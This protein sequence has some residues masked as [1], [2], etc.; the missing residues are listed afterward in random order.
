MYWPYL[1]GENH[2]KWRMERPQFHQHNYK[3]SN[4]P[5]EAILCHPDTWLIQRILRG[6]SI[7]IPTSITQMP[8]KIN[9]LGLPCK[10]VR[11]I[12]NTVYLYPSRYCICSRINNDNMLIHSDDIYLNGIIINHYLKMGTGPLKRSNYLSFEHQNWKSISYNEDNSTEALEYNSLLMMN[13]L[14]FSIIC[15]MGRVWWGFLT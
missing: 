4:N 6:F 2:A 11:L 15:R 9:S 1:V 12:N 3:A 5:A 7:S 14:Y 10:L 13:I 8:G